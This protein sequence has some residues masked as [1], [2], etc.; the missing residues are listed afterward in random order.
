[1]VLDLLVG[2]RGRVR[3]CLLKPAHWKFTRWEAGNRGMM[4]MIQSRLQ[5]FLVGVLSRNSDI[6]VDDV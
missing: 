6:I 2:S 1:M 4:K 5:V 3:D